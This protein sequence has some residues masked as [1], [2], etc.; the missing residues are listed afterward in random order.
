MSQLFEDLLC[1]SAEML[2][3]TSVC[4]HFVFKVCIKD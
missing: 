1:L 2:F 3:Q 4:Q